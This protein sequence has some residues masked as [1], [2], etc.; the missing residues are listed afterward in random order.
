MS[1]TLG[2]PTI[3]AYNSMTACKIT[4]PVTVT[5]S[6]S[7]ATNPPYMKA[8]AAYDYYKTEVST[9]S[10][11]GGTATFSVVGMITNRS[12]IYNGQCPVAE[13]WNSDSSVHYIVYGY[14]TE[15]NEKG[16][17]SSTANVTQA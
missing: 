4:I 5:Y 16:R 10:A 15:K 8:V 14:Q 9:V 7:N 11:G 12:S 2:T 17:W 6:P 1:V 3:E 13:V